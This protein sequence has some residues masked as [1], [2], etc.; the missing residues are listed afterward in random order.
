MAINF[1]VQAQVVDISTDVPQSGDILFVDT[2]V[3]FWQTYAPATTPIAVSPSR[4]RKISVYLN[5]MSDALRVG[6]T[7]CYSGLS[8][9]EL[10]HNIEKLEQQ[11]SPYSSVSLKEYRH[12]YPSE[13]ARV[14]AEVQASWGQINNIAV[15][16]SLLIDDLT[17]DR[18]LQ[19]FQTQLLDGY[20]VYIL[21]TMQ[22]IQGITGVITDDGDYVTA[23]GVAMFTFNYDAI[24]AARNQG[25][26]LVR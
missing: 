5:Y 14:V 10:A 6:A 24:A 20:D 3:W 2:N 13:R 8:L 4:L 18:A 22:R 12:N 9:A 21:E 15:S 19:R 25:K 23:S 11:N 26:L 16:E 17:I 1:R 7:L